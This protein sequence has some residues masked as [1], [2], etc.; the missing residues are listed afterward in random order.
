M[1]LNKTLMT[2]ALAAGVASA[3]HA[4]TQNVYISGSTAFRAQIYNALAD[5]GLTV[6][7][8][9][10]S[11][12]NQ[13]NFTGTVNN[14]QTTYTGG[15]YTTLSGGTS[16]QIFCAFSGS[17][18]GIYSEINSAQPVPG[19]LAI[20]STTPGTASAPDGADIIFSD[21]QQ[22]STQYTSTALNELSTADGAAS[23]FGSGVGVVPFTWAVSAAGGGANPKITGISAPE[24]YALFTGGSAPLSFWTGISGDASTSVDLIG[25][26]NDSGTRITAELTAGFP[27]ASYDPAQP[28]TQ[29]YLATHG[30]ANNN[31]NMVTDLATLPAAAANNVYLAISA[32]DAGVNNL[33]AL[34]GSGYAGYSSGGNVAKALA[35]GGVSPTPAY[36]VGYVAWSDAASLSGGAL[37]IL[38]QSE[39]PTS[40][41]PITTTSFTP[42]TTAWNI[43]GVENGAYGFWSYEHCYTS[44]NSSSFAVNSFGPD[45]LVAL[46]YEIIHTTPQTA[47]VIANLNV[48]R[49]ADGGP[50][51]AGN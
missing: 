4:Q 40:V 5:L 39:N 21:V 38:Y 41:Y 51:K 8:G 28:I 35:R 32:G 24:T 48:H 2:L 34:T 22:A 12:A 15:S 33:T 46:E 42:G 37:P 31:A 9:L 7:N 17:S 13:F 44:A 16:V 23:S 49:N 47:D 3:A 6:G 18:E 45:L 50:L 11:S 43:A 19:Y 27:V 29:Y 26:T 20:G 36:A 10:T 25:R 1:K 30:T 14:S